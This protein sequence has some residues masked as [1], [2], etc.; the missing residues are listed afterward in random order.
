MS[1]YL[2]YSFYDQGLET[3]K[4]LH[5][6]H[7]LLVARRDGRLGRADYALLVYRESPAADSTRIEGLAT[8]GDSAWSIEASCS[9]DQLP[10]G[11]VSTLERIGELPRR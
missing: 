5:P 9:T 2:P 10:D 1:R 11:L 4:A 6:A 7:Q 8:V 3:L